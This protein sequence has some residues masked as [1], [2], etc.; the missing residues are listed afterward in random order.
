MVRLSLKTSGDVPLGLKTSGDVSLSL[1]SDAQVVD[2][3][4]PEYTGETEVI[5][6]KYGQVLQTKDTS[7]YSDITV[8]AIPYYK[9]SNESGGYTA[10]IGE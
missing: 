4:L 10:I 8:Q 7:V 5:P 1:K 9:T 6:A 2:T 3:R